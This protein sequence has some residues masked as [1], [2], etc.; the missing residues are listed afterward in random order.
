MWEYSLNFVLNPEYYT[1]VK[2]PP[3]FSLFKLD[4][5]GCVSLKLGPYVTQTMGK[6]IV[7]LGA[8]LP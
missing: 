5:T 4:A 6:R 1:G 2:L 7:I 3:Y 8:N